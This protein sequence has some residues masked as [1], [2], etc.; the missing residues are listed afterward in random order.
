MDHSLQTIH[1]LGPKP[2]SFYDPSLKSGLGYQ[3]PCRLQKAIAQTPKLY[4]ATSLRD[5][6]V[7]VHVHDSEEILEDAE[8]S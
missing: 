1:M 2:N 6:K 4:S 8:K 5:S 3:N 7:H